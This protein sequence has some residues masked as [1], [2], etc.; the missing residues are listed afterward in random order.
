MKNIRFSFRLGHEIPI[1]FSIGWIFVYLETG[2]SILKSR[3][4]GNVGSLPLPSHSHL[5]PAPL[6]TGESRRLSPVSG[7]LSAIIRF[8]TCALKL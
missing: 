2:Q 8:S 6:A 3:I 4:L 7:N 5:S 1:P